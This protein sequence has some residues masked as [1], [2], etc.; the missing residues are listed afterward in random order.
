MFHRSRSAEFLTA[1]RGRKIMDQLLAAFVG[2]RDTR[3]LEALVRRHAPMVWG[4]CRRTLTHHDAEEAFHATFLVLVRRAASIT[5]AARSVRG[6]TLDE[7]DRLVERRPA[8]ADV[9]NRAVLE[10][11]RHATEEDEL[12]RG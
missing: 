7:R 3:A 9:I 8:R 10:P 4:V 6:P 5:P 11:D 2:Q 1:R 12:R